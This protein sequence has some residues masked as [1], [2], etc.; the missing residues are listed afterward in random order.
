[1]TDRR[2]PADQDAL[3]F[4]TVVFDA[5]VRLLELQARSFSLFVD[6]AA[7]SAIVVL[8]NSVRGLSRRQRTRLR[9]AYGSL[10]SRVTIRRTGTL[11]DPRAATGWRSQQAAKLAVSS[12]IATPHYVVMDAKNHFTRETGA[13]AFVAADGRAH[14]ALHSYAEHP[15]RPSL[16]STLTYLGAESSVIRQAVESFPPTATPFVFDTALVRSMVDD[17]ARRSGR[18]FDVE[19]ERA[20]L[21]EFFLYSGWLDVHG[22]GIA[23]AI[24]G[25][26]IPSPTVWPRL[27]TME[28]VESVIREA[29]RDDAFVFAVHRQALARADAAT[30][31]RIARQWAE[32]G[33][34]PDERAAGRFVR[35]F[36]HSYLP[37]LVRTRLAE[38]ARAWVRPARR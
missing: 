37:A 11:I 4:V 34:F 7:V 16:E 26:S 5:E 19:F 9:N 1:M 10:W 32:I 22:P 3:T 17:L 33:L 18:S 29:E 12:L 23:A 30:R 38:R 20:E 28:G 8:D 31:A 6:P 2:P 21:L 24:D 14:G 13:A 27:A 35:A 25:A 36:R 15:L